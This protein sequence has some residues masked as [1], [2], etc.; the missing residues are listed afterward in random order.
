MR[1]KNVVVAFFDTIQNDVVREIDRCVHTEAFQ[2]RLAVDFFKDCSEYKDDFI[3][4]IK[5]ESASRAEV[6]KAKPGA[7]F[8]SNAHLG[9]AVI[10]G[11]ALSTL[12]K[13]KYELWLRDETL[14]LWDMGRRYD[15]DRYHDYQRSFSKLL[16][17]QRQELTEAEEAAAR[18]G[19]GSDGNAAIMVAG[20]MGEKAYKLNGWYE[21]T[22]L[23]NGKPLF[24]KLKNPDVWLRFTTDNTWMFSDTSDTILNNT[25][26]WCVSVEADKDLPTHVDCWKMEEEEEEEEVSENECEKDGEEEEEEEEVDDEDSEKDSAEEVSD[27]EEECEQEGEVEEGEDEVHH[28]DSGKDSAEEEQEEK[29]H[30][31]GVKWKDHAQIKCI[32]A[33]KRLQALALADCISRRFLADEDELD[34]ADETTSLTPL[35]Q[36][37]SLGDFKVAERLLQA[38]ASPEH[39]PSQDEEGKTPLLWASKEGYADAALLLLKYK[40]NTEATTKVSYHPTFAYC[41]IIGIMR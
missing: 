28:Q 33:A 4:S 16:A 38:R 18:E 30:D 8:A 10:D 17:L 27:N 14:S 24:R 1:R 31:L 22:D 5:S 23:Q 25:D 7:W 6:Y 3:A 37:L 32:D 39:V 29:K 11:L 21:T 15:K 19:E 35:W 36:H 40:A 34:V 12:A 2:K 20:V 26:G 9:K 13:A 41:S